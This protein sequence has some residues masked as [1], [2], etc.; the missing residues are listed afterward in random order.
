VVHSGHFL[1]PFI[2]VSNAMG[3]ADFS[4]AETALRWCM[5]NERVA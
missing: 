2:K 5:S 1:N 4:S 3:G